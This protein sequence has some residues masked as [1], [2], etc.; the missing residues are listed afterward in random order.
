M[1]G[2][3]EPGIGLRFFVKDF[4]TVKALNEYLGRVLESDP[5]LQGFWLK[6]E[7]SGYKL[8]QASG[9]MYFTLKDEDAVVSC[10]MF[11]SATAIEKHCRKRKQSAKVKRKKSFF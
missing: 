7:I 2:R 9:H 11:R 3:L 1:Q 4:I 10:V 6:G 5:I 8:Y